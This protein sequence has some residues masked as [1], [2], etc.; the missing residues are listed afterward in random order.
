M[1]YQCPLC[2]QALQQSLQQWRCSNNH[3]FDCAKEGYVNLMP[4]QYKG[5]K[6]PGDSPE[7]MQAR[8]AFLD[9]GY[10]QPLQ[11]QVCD[12]LDKALPQDAAMLLDIG[13]GEGY[14]TAAVADR[15]NRQ[16]QM[17]IFGLDVAKVAVRYGAKR[18]PQVSFCVASSHR[19]PFANHALDAV[20]RIYAPCKAT[21][22]ARTVKP[23][24][25]VVTVAPG[26]RHLY[27]LK[28]LIYAQVQLHDDTPEHLD[29]FDLISSEKLAYEMKLTGK[30]SFNLL[31]MTPFAWRAS[32]ETGQELAAR[33]CFVCETDFVIAVH[34]RREDLASTA[35]SSDEKLI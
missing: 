18:Y 2:H 27:Q 22:L 7:M 33:Q 1:S 24:G 6:Q 31:Q 20:L 35:L 26:P 15:L 29:G 19:L 12:I 9:A 3:Q 11:Q 4:V 16:R 13:C 10:Y 5:S 30:Q 17:A 32:I 21:E 25:I 14:Y 23:G 28:A 8:R 34:R